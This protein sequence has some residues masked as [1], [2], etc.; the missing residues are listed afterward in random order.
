MYLNDE[1]LYEIIEIDMNAQILLKLESL[2]M[3]NLL[4]IVVFEKS[5]TL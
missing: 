1:I 5:F 2:Y 4:Q 3:T